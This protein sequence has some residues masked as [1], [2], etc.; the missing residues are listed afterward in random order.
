MSLQLLLRHL[1]RRICLWQL[2]GLLMR[3]LCWRKVLEA[4]RHWDTPPQSCAGSDPRRY[5]LQ[6]LE[7]PQGCHHHCQSRRLLPRLHQMGCCQLILDMEESEMVVNGLFDN[8]HFYWLNSIQKKSCTIFKICIF[9]CFI[10]LSVAVQVNIIDL[11]LGW[12]W[13][14][15]L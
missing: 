3:R 14:Y 13:I 15:L 12:G 8:Q 1:L 10:E 5:G 2:E 11:Q 4:P 6:E 7:V 9:W